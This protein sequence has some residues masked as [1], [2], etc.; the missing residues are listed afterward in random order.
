M[1]NAILWLVSLAA[2]LALAA[3]IWF[4]ALD[5]FIGSENVDLARRRA[6]GALVAY[7]CLLFA[8][9]QL[10]PLAFRHPGQA[11]LALVATAV[12]LGVVESAAHA[13]VP[14]AAVLS[15]D[16]GGFRS[17]QFHHIY[18]PNA[19]R[20]MGR[21]EGTPVFLDT[22]EDG[23]RTRYSKEEFRKHDH[24]VIVLG[25]SFTFGLG[26]PAEATFA[27]L[28]EPHLRHATG[29][30]S[31]AVLNAGIVSYSPFLE[32][33]LLE[34][35]LADYRP[36]LVVLMLDVTDIG[37]DYAYMRI[38][39]RSGNSW[40]FPFDDAPPV[41]YRGALVELTRPYR[42]RLTSAFMYPLQLAGYQNTADA[43]EFDYYDFELPIGGV[44][45][46]DRYF[47]LRHPLD[48]TRQ[49]FDSTVQNIDSIAASAARLGAGFVLA[50]TPRYHHWNPS[51]CPN[52]WERREYAL[53][54]PYQFEYFRYFAGLRR[55]YP[56]VDLLPDFRSTT[57]YPLVFA[58][59][60]HWNAAGH[61]FV[62]DIVSKHLVG[63]Q[64]LM[65]ASDRAS[66]LN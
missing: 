23:L 24:R 42:R 62:A 56:I 19:R 58:E 47:V 11:A 13:F 6:V 15:L 28:M 52:N 35:K 2:V 18:P 40:E 49:Y 37:D 36:T 64:M 61:A 4:G 48:D 10:V 54:E 32:H 7:W 38:A 43:G 3:S 21:F 9:V 57:R 44:V 46:K 27:P 65:T 60:P 50:I 31:V 51:E 45:E 5:L 33:L 22:N 14:G 66:R 39:K 8:V 25:D 55:D 29:G 16:V 1:R 17:R 30:A 12:T 53:A 34:R 63:R 20:Y 59:D 41:P 26:V